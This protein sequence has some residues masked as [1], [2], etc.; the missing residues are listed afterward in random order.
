MIIVSNNTHSCLDYHMR[1]KF[2]FLVIEFIFISR[3]QS[4]QNQINKDHLIARQHDHSAH[5]I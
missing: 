1:S 2:I 5:K 4:V 3:K